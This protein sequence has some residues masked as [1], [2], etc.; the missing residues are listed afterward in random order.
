[1][2][3]PGFGEVA[4]RLRRSTVQVQQTR[5]RAQGGGSG[6]IWSADGLIITNAHVAHG[7]HAKVSLWDGTAYDASVL[8]RDTRRDLAS[9]KIHATGLPAATPGDSSALRVGELVIA[10]GN[11]FG[12]IGALTTGVVHALP[13]RQLW[14]AA[15]VRLAPGNSGGP[16]ADAQGRVIGINTMIAG[17]LALAVPSNAVGKFLKGEI[18]PSLGITLQPVPLP[19]GAFGF[20]LLKVDPGSAAEVASLMIGDLLVGAAGK[21]FASVDDLHAAV[22]S[23]GELLDLQFRRGDRRATRSTAVRLRARKPEAA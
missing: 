22:E 3:T 7:S 20:L 17:G 21:P 6:I 14:V 19:A 13:G 8:N 18:G 15:D 2:T 12:F 16:L 23:S 10:I 4:E 11:P 1:M 9:L 5:G